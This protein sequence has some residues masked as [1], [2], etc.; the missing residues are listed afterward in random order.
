MPPKRTDDEQRKAKAAAL[1]AKKE[2]EQ[3][4]AASATQLRK[5]KQFESSLDSDTLKLFKEIQALS[6][7][8]EINKENPA[9]LE[10]VKRSKVGQQAEN[11]GIGIDGKVGLVATESIE[12]QELVVAAK[13]YFPSHLARANDSCQPDWKRLVVDMANRKDTGDDAKLMDEMMSIWNEYRAKSRAA[14]NYREAVPHDVNILMSRFYMA[15]IRD[16]NHPAEPN[17][18]APAHIAVL[19]T[20]EPGQEFFRSYDYIWLVMAYQHL[21]ATVDQWGAGQNVVWRLANVEH[22]KFTG[23]GCMSEH[24]PSND[25]EGNEVKLPMM[26]VSKKM[27]L[28]WTKLIRRFF[29][30][31][32]KQLPDDCEKTRA[33]TVFNGIVVRVCLPCAKDRNTCAKHVSDLKIPGEQWPRPTRG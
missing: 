21:C 4:A 1:K 6:R 26:W 12:P 22:L 31:L 17:V 9:F 2:K 16:K 30:H 7:D 15:H 29:L 25:G 8:P 24:P 27:A 5:Q 3:K 14:E 18:P 20:I 33:K 11:P 32:F 19:K 23:M 28:K 13:D 10:V